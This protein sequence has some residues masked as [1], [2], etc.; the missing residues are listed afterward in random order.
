MQELDNQILV[1]SS[2]IAVHAD[3]RGRLLVSADQLRTRYELCEDLASAL[4]EQAQT[5]FHVQAPS[6]SEVLQRIHAGLCSVESGF[7]AAEAAWVVSRLAELLSWPC[8][9]LVTPVTSEADAPPA[10]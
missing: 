1:P 7:S 5:L 8:P 2:F 3:A 4:V 6:E 9:A 10:N